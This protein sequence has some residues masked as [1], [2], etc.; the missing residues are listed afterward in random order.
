MRDPQ[1]VREP[2]DRVELIQLQVAKAG[3]VVSRPQRKALEMLGY[4]SERLIL[5]E[6]SESP[7]NYSTRLVV[8]VDG[9]RRIDVDTDGGCEMDDAVASTRKDPPC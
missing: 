2:L 9:S 8:E 7:C 3:L 5:R 6:L 4:L 1:A